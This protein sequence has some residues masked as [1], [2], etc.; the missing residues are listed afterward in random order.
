MKINRQQALEIAETFRDLSVA[1][2]DYR[3]KNWS[4]LTPGKR[5]QIE[6]IEWTLLNYSSDFI[7]TAV[8]INL[9]NLQSDL[10]AIKKSTADAK[11]AIRSINKIKDV[12][13]VAT[14]VAVLG[15]AIASQNPSAI[16]AAANDLIT[17]T[18]KLS[19]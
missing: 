4:K 2:G 11:K 16:L 10:K 15:G 13:N 7:T 9:D 17:T 3:F 6:N 18:K 19:N 1:L 14:S 5:T 12:I 8:R